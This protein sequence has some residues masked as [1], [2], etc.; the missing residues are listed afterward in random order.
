MDT[1]RAQFD[2][3]I[4]RAQDLS[5]LRGPSFD[6]SLAERGEGFTGLD[7]AIS[8]QVGDGPLFSAR[9]AALWERL[10]PELT[11]YTSARRND[12]RVDARVD[13]QAG[14]RVSTRVR[15]VRRLAPARGRRS[16]L[17]AA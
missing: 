4:A 15:A 17:G 6:A 13:A 12:T 3:V 2:K 9:Y 7:L 5:G 11:A 14:T 1:T 10:R 16:L 8:E